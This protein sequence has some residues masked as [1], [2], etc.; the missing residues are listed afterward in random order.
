MDIREENC[1][2]KDFSEGTFFESLSLKEFNDE[3]EG[4]DIL[5][6]DFSNLDPD[7]FDMEDYNIDFSDKDVQAFV[8]RSYSNNKSLLR[9]YGPLNPNIPCNGYKKLCVFSPNGI[10]AMMTCR[11]YEVIDEDNL[12]WFTGICACCG[13]EIESRNKA[14][15][16]PLATGGFKYC[17]C[18]D[19]CAH[20]FYEFDLEAIEHNFI[21]I[22]K[23]YLV[24]YP[25]FYIDEDVRK[26]DESLRI[27]NKNK[28]DQLQYEKEMLTYDSDEEP[29]F[30]YKITSLDDSSSSD[31]EDASVSSDCEDNCGLI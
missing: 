7:K 28:P 22:I 15:R 17:L 19:I 3:Y 26:F 14:F 6:P 12:D 27:L 18:S 1:E 4:D 21:D 25:I 2:T 9:K 10:C 30:K 23:A 5:G 20:S 24:I 11:C 29:V 8:R 16:I 31:C 13:E